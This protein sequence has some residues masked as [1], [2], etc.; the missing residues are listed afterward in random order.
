MAHGCQSA[1]MC[2]ALHR[3]QI[4][5]LHKH[6]QQVDPISNTV[7]MANCGTERLLYLLKNKAQNQPSQAFISSGLASECDFFFF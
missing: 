5:R 6:P 4:P 2:L 7:Q 3:H 1:T